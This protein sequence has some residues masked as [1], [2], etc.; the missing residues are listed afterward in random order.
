MGFIVLVLLLMVAAY[1]KFVVYKNTNTDAQ[2][3]TITYRIK[4]SNIR[5]Y[6]A[7]AFQIGDTVYD[8]QTKLVIGK[9]KDIEKTNAK[10]NKETVDG[11]IIYAESLERYDVVLTIETEGMETDKAYF[12]DRSV[13]LKVGSEKQ[14]ETR[15]VKTTGTIVEVGK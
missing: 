5:S 7:D 6:S 8:S 1:W 10:I 9:I 4:I 14:I 12:A 3:L 15:Y 13:E 2:M 11:R